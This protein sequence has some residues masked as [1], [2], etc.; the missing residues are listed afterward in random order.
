MDGTGNNMATAHQAVKVFWLED[1]PTEIED[2]A[3]ELIADGVI[4][5]IAQGFVALDDQMRCCEI[6]GHTSQVIAIILD[7]M[8]EGVSSLRGL[9]R[10]IPHADTRNGYAAGLV[11]LERVLCDSNEYPSFKGIPV[12]LHSKRALDA[13]DEV[14]RI[15]GISD[16]DKRRVFVCAKMG[17]REIVDQVR[18]LVRERNAQKVGG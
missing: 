15:R 2:A 17:S 9:Y 3:N 11:F 4:V 16:R 10:G 8:I 13:H 14:E 5:Q 1:V 6:A 12:I 7:V 18:R